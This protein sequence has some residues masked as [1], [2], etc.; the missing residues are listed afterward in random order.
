M[1]STVKLSHNWLIVVKV[2]AKGRSKSLQ[3][4]TQLILFYLALVTAF[5]GIRNNIRFNRLIRTVRKNNVSSGIVNKLNYF[6]ECNNMI[7]V[8]LFFYGGSFFILCVDGLTSQTIAKSKLASDIVI[9]NAN[10]CVAFYYLLFVSN[11]GTQALMYSL[12]SS[13]L[14]F[15]LPPSTSVQH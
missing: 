4:F 1:L 12:S 6:R 8:V 13:L 7:C 15:Y 11:K 3:W 5:L 9:S 10:V 2:S 14:D